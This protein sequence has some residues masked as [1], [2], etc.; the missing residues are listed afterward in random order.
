[1]KR[2]IIYI[3]SYAAAILAAATPVV[4]QVSKEVEVTQ[5]Y[6]PQVREATKPTLQPN[7]EDDAYIAP[8]I[9]Y[10]I[11]STSIHT[12]LESEP[13]KPVELDYWEFKR[14]GDYYAK[15]GVG[16]PYRSVVDL[17]ASRSSA[18]RGYY[19][20]FVNQEGEYADR[21]NDY[22]VSSDAVESHLRVG[23]TA[24]LYVGRRV[25]EGAFDYRNDYWSRYATSCDDDNNPLYQRLVLDLRYGDNF[26]D[27]SRWNYSVEAGAEH[28]WS[29][30]G[31]GNTSM[32]GRVDLG[33]NVAG[34]ALR[35]SA[36][37]DCTMGDAGYLNTTFGVGARYSLEGVVSNLSLGLDLY[38]DN[39][40]ATG[41][42][43]KSHLYISPHLSY[44]QRLFE[45]KMIAYLNLG[46]R[47]RHNDYASLSEENP[48]IEAGLFGDRSSLSYD[49][50]LGIKGVLDDRIFSYNLYVGYEIVT[51]ERYWLYCEQQQSATTACSGYVVAF[52]DLSTLSVDL[53]MLYR[54]VPALEIEFGA[55]VNKYY[56]A[57]GA[58]AVARPTTELNL[59]GLYRVGKMAFGVGAEFASSRKSS[60]LYCDIVG[61]ESM[62]TIVTPSAINLCAE[63]EY[64]LGCGAVVF[65]NLTNL[66]NDDIYEWARFREYGVGG[67][68]GVKFEF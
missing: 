41:V 7:M 30:S 22:G 24:G 66:L 6:I 4:A 57:S 2:D 46:G 37:V 38:S 68:I 17:Y 55:S 25:L 49:L 40:S 10:T 50:D 8:D 32:G 5:A 21:T 34:G 35:L 51:D 36:L 60:Q 65:C 29:R 27:L 45:S 14:L 47:V 3:C 42:D 23:S 39:V 18:S 67:V 11:T 16:M 13:Y 43:A 48:Y 58:W 52:D 62:S 54:P 44:D 33:H 63:A 31:Y 1:M 56:E 61:G 59:G 9:D 26:S 53:E 64:T 28:M 12:P 19:N 20:A 15:V